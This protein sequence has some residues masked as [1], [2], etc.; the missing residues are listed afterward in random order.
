MSAAQTLLITAIDSLET[1][2]T[3]I[4]QAADLT[5]PLQP[6]EQAYSDTERALAETWT[7]LENENKNEYNLRM[8]I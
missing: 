8:D 7:A 3:M 4:G 6:L 2:L 5:D 1:A